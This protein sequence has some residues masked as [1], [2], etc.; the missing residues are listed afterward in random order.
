MG[1]DRRNITLFTVPL[2]HGDEGS[3]KPL[4]KLIPKAV[5]TWKGPDDPGF[6]PLSLP[7]TLK[8]INDRSKCS[9]TITQLQALF[10][11]WCRSDSF[12]WAGEII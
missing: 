9:A 5:R 12:N 4:L 7:K 3:M 2:A 1:V 6:H 11:L 8:F 10:P